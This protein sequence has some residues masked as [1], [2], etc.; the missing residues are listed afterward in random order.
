MFHPAG[1]P[2]ERGWVG[3]VDGDRVVHLAAQTLVSFFT[4]GGSAREHDVY[5]LAEVRLL[6]PVLHPPSIRIF[7][8][9]GGCAFANPAAIVGPGATVGRRAELTL[10]PRLA[11]VVGAEGR[12]S[13]FTIFAE[14]RDPSQPPPKDRDFAFGLGPVAV[15]TDEL[16]PGGRAVAVRVDGVERSTATFGRFDW[17]AAVAL[18]AEGTKLYP[19]DLIAGPAAGRVDGVAAGSLVEVDVDGIGVLEQALGAA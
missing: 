16:E 6:A 17:Q 14:W 15:T 4:G 8:E 13:A 18:A 19:G 2:L 5:A 7:D 1:H 9:V 11:A 12:A 3:R 10:L